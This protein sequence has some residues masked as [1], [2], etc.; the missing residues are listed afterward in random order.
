MKFEEVLP[1]MRDEGWIARFGGYLRFK[2]SEGCLWINTNFPGSGWSPHHELNEEYFLQ[3]RWELEP[4]KVSK[5]RWVFGYGSQLQT[6][7]YAHLSESEA[8]EY[9][10]QKNFGWAERIEHTHTEVEE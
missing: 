10:L 1:K 5:W 7:S 2:L 6:T 3:D 9:K 8:E 4:V